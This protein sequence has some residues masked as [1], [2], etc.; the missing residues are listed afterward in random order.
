MIKDTLQGSA[1]SC[2][3]IDIH[4]VAHNKY[5]G[6]WNGV[7]TIG[8][9]GKYSKRQWKIQNCRRLYEIS[10]DRQSKKIQSMLTIWPA[11]LIIPLYKPFLCSE[12]DCLR[13]VTVSC[14]DRMKG[15]L[16]YLRRAALP[17][18]ISDRTMNT[19]RGNVIENACNSSL[20]CFEK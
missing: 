12:R 18:V 1:N 4:E 9:T 17:E 16:W 10:A 5:R 11:Y 7:K 15:H 3:K 14:M 19:G 6:Q 13:F 2:C 8:G 20:P